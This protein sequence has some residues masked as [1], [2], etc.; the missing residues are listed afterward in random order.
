MTTADVKADISLDEITPWS[1]TFK[2]V[3]PMAIDAD[4]TTYVTLSDGIARVDFRTVI[5]NRAEDHRLRALF[6]TDIDTM[7]VYAEGQFD[8]VRR[9][10]TPAPTWKN[11]CNAQRD[12]AFITLESESGSDAL[13][14]AN[15]GLCEYEILRDGRNTAAITLLRAIGQIGDWGVFPTPLG[16]KKGT[17]TLEYSLI[18]YDTDAQAEAY[19]LGYTFAYPA[20]AAIGTPKHEGTLPATAD[21]VRFDSEYIRASAFKKA[22]DSNS[23]ILRLFNTHTSTVT[24]TLDVPAFKSASLTNL[25]EEKLSDLEIKS[26]KIT[27]DIG[28]KKIMTIELI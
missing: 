17:W 18:P 11:P 7:S 16:Q 23:V 20:I 21:F 13:M 28:A 26:G 24:L 6:T 4:I 2:A 19:G 27:L 12:Q 15:R 25:A 8:I 5:T 9:D 3:V 22:E 10:I 1:V 14:I